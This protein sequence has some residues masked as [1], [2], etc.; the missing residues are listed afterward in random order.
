MGMTVSEF[1]SRTPSFCK[2]VAI[3]PLSYLT[4]LIVK[5]LRTEDLLAIVI[6]SDTGQFS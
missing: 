4:L 6:V 2:G 5:C 3:N 1:G